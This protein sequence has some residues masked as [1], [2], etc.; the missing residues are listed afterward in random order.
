[1]HEIQ[2]KLIALSQT[3]NLS[4]LGLREIGR[5][6]GEQHPQKVKY[7]M[8]LL[9]LLDSTKRPKPRRVLSPQQ[10]NSTRNIAH[11]PIL[12]LAN[13][14]DATMLADAQ[15]EGHLPVSKKLL[16]PKDTSDLFAVRA[17]GTSMNKSNINQK[18]IDDGDYVVIDSSDTLPRD[19]EYVLSVINGAANI[20]KYHE[21][22]VNNQI[23]LE[24]ESTNYF[25]PI[26]LHK[27]DL[28]GYLV[29]GKVV[30]VIKA[31]K[32]DDI[33]YEPFSS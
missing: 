12:G 31:P 30:Q 2:K 28:S 3:H 21:D 16:K 25:P 22:N 26:Y 10:T 24:S 29:N 33:R 32:N 17:V 1:M 11:I 27:D 7:H 4:K 18:T 9:G 19:G 15:V 5:L 14:G 13:C 6:I 8:Q 23:V 20:K